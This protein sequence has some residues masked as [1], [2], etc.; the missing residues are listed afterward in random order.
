MDF[1]QNLA[2]EPLTV[3]FAL[4]LGLGL[5][6]G[7]Q[8]ERGHARL[9]GVRTF[10]LA[11]LFG[12]LSAV[13]AERYGGSLV[14]VGVIALVAL[15]VVGNVAKMR[16]EPVDP[17][18][19]TEVALLLMFGV[20][21]LL[22]VGSR[23][24]AIALGGGVAVLLQ[25]KARLHGWIDRLGDQDFG[26]IMRFALIALVIL[27]LLPDRAM[28]PYQVWNP[29]SIWWMVLL[30][31]AISLAGYLGF[32]LFG[33]RAGA[34]VA[35]LL[36]GLIS[37]TA[38][39]VSY[40]RRS[41]EQPEL[42]RVGVFVVLA[43]SGVVFARLLV[44]VAVVAPSFLGAAALPLGV[45]LGGFALVAVAAWRG[46]G[47]RGATPLE[48]ENPTELRPALLFGLLYGA[49]LLAVAVAKDHFGTA[50]LYTVATLSG[51]TDMDAITLSTARLVAAGTLD[52]DSG[53]RTL[54]IASLSNLGFKAALVTALGNRRMSRGVALGYLAAAL[55]GVACWWLR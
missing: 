25:L 29:R 40:A 28:G 4:S 55:G 53:W 18:L 47:E 6:V 24:L 12:T 15:L 23:P 35:G 22:V 50:G 19:T 44:E 48:P 17:G 9:A 33:A 10:A 54:L 11:T 20:G 3:T 37:S 21:A 49:V 14:A 39:A 26:A 52:A 13:L 45:L 42:A 7:M 51:L 46:Q 34:L 27:P 32:K 30:I 38:T 31:V 36:G 43:S 5:L 1:A 41:R 2:L 8:R 16:L